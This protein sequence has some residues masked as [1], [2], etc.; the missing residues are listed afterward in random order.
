VHPLPA[1]CSESTRT[2][3]EDRVLLVT[4]SIPGNGEPEG[5]LVLIRL[6]ETQGCTVERV[7]TERSALEAVR[8][9]SYLCVLVHVKGPQGLLPVQA[10]HEAHLEAP[11]AVFCE[12]PDLGVAVAA[13]RLGTF[14]YLVGPPEPSAVEALLRR[15]QGSADLRLR[16]YTQSLRA[17]TPGLIHELRNPLSGILASGQMLGRL[18]GDNPR[19][20]EYVRIL[21]EE[22]LQLERFLARLGEFSR[23]PRG[24]VFFAGPV[25][26]TVF[27]TAV[28]EEW[29]P[30]C[31]AHG[32]GQV[33]HYDPSI[34]GIRAEPTRLSLALGEILANA[35]EAMPT[36]GTLSVTTRR[37]AGATAAGDGA[38]GGWA[39]IL[40]S[41]TGG[42]MAEEVHRRAFEPFFSTRPRALG[43]GLALAQA[44]VAAH[45]G[46]LRLDSRPGSGT[47]VLLRLH[48]APT[49]ESGR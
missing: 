42:G 18:I 12:T 40:V 36:G 21:R 4:S 24:G 14:D 15:S 17:L 3:T 7:P 16:G 2:A 30:R 46:S 45:G 44:I 22:A 25:D 47:Q 28:L 32:I 49:G 1:T 11:L 23:L 20:Q 27:L 29:R 41:D 34:S 33:A 43:I 39:D 19:A 38:P 9:G 8:R 13:L 26:L 35:V 5:L 31:T 10:L 6:L 48:L 37:V